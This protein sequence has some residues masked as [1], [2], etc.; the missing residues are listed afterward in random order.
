MIGLPEPMIKLGETA[1]PGDGSDIKIPFTFRSWV[2]I[3]G[4]IL[5]GCFTT[6]HD[7]SR[8]PRIRFGPMSAS[9]SS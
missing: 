5:G 7:S 2:T 8:K 1:T 9:H 6:L 4:V 3:E